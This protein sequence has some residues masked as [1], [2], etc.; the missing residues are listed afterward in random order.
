M[1]SIRGSISS[2]ISSF[3]RFVWRLELVRIN[4]LDTMQGL[5]LSREV[6]EL[7]SKKIK[8]NEL[9]YNLFVLIMRINENIQLFL[10]KNL[11]KK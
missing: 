8:L 7:Q 4:Y 11:L 5:L 10:L 3:T 2:E 9:V 6:T 1:I